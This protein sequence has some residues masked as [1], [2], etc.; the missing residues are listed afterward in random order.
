MID[1]ENKEVLKLRPAD[2]E[3][4]SKYVSP[5]FVEGEYIIQA[6]R[7][8]RDGIIFTN[9]RMIAI[10]IQG[11]TGKKK[12]FTS[13]P[14]NRIQA[15]SVETAGIFDLDSLL[16]LW[17]CGMG[18]IRFEFVARANVYEICRVISENSL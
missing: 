10:N 15:Y 13:L 16:E 1:F 7:S 12:V 5:M 9:K 11:V 6:F 4:F 18:R 3:D 17:F 14:Y 8:I 2:D